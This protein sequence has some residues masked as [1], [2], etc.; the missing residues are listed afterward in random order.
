MLLRVKADVAAWM[1]LFSKLPRGRQQGRIQDAQ[2]GAVI[3]AGA[4][5]TIARLF[6][7]GVILKS[8]VALF[9]LENWYDEK[10][11]DFMRLRPQFSAE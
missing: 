2:Q 6:R 10:L 4:S 11:A 1:N 9:V 5:L 8:V 3:R 7:C